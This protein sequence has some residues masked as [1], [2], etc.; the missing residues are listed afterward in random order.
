MASGSN[1]LRIFFLLVLVCAAHAGKPAPKEKSDSKE[2]KKSDGKAGVPAEGPSGSAE[3]SGP[4]GSFD[5]S[6]LGAK[7]DGKTDSTK[8]LEEA[9]A[10]ACAKEGKQTILIPK[11]DYL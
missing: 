4:G 9:W 5:I 6:K 11:G 3:A 1:A 10:S 2:E 7:G 8:A